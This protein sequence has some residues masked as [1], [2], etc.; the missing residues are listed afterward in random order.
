MKQI[1]MYSHFRCFLVIMRLT[2]F[3]WVTCSPT[4]HLTDVAQQFWGWRTLLHLGLT[5]MEESALLVNLLSLIVCRTA[6]C[7]K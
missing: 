3:V 6:L 7:F 4:R 2:A 5:P 1:C